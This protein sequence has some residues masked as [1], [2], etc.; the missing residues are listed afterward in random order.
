MTSQ[1]QTPWDEQAEQA[2]LGAMLLSP[3]VVPIVSTIVAPEEFYEQRHQFIARAIYDCGDQADMITVPERLRAVGKLD[4]CGGEY[5]LASL[6]NDV[7]TSSAVR[8]ARIVA[9]RAE[10][11]RILAACSAIA[12]TAY[13]LR[14]ESRAIYG[15]AMD[16]LAKA[17]RPQLHASDS[18]PI[19]FEKTLTLF[20]RRVANQGE[21]LGWSS[22]VQDLDRLTAGWQRGRL[23][24]IGGRPGAGKSVLVAQ[25]ALRASLAGAKVKYYTLEMSAAEVVLRM[26]KNHA[27]VG[28]ATGAE[29]RLSE[30]DRQAVRR[31]IGEVA[32]L[33]DVRTTSSVNAIIAE[34][35][36]EHRCGALDMVV[37]DQLQNATP[38]VGRRESS[39]RDLELSAATR[40]LKLMA[41][42]L[43]IAV[44]MC[45][46]LNRTNEGGKPTLAN[47]RESG[48]IESDSDVACLLWTP[49]KDQQPDVIEAVLAKN[50]DNSIGD[51]RMYFAR[52]MHRMADAVKV[53]L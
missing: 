30:T 4:E 39:T 46:A 14:G 52:P 23:I 37:I 47:L 7:P 35:E 25:S 20:E 8:Y 44:L 13:D 41:L 15:T 40:A 5:Y 29:H 12:R 51:A 33:V 34:C 31:A 32:E 26:A 28:Y 27:R 50:R 48:G 16:E 38:D 19:V 2:T 42:R 6:V 3:Q 9:D 53:E 17:A 18:M 10:R 22:G 24:T 1:L 49:D 43:N 11:R 36:V 21:L 45:S